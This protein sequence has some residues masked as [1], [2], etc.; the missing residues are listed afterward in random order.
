MVSVVKA[1]AVCSSEILV[2]AYKTAQCHNLQDQSNNFHLNENLRFI[3]LFLL[4]SCLSGL[5]AR[6][7]FEVRITLSSLGN[8]KRY[9]S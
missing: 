5:A 7:P 8:P 9:N 6:N 4:Q 2:L 3:L 1:E